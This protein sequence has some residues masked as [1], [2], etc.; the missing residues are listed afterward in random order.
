MRELRE[1]SRR[2]GEGAL[3][4]AGRDGWT[5]R[6]G[7]I[8]QCTRADRRVDRSGGVDT[9]ARRSRDH[10]RG[11][12]RASRRTA[13]LPARDLKAMAAR[14]FVREALAR[15]CAGTSIDLPEDVAHHAIRV[16]RLGVG[17]ALTLFDGTGGEYAASVTHIDRRTARV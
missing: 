7:T 9:R 15:D 13:R 12:G 3:S 17:D 14:F 2:R 16:T 11:A 8:A 4:R 5:R 1:R 10:G 6:H